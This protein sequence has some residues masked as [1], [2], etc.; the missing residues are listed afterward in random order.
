MS[1]DKQLAYNFLGNI[2]FERIGGTAEENKAVRLLCDMARSFEAIPIVERFG[3]KT[4]TK[5]SAGLEILTPYQTKYS[6]TPCALSGSFPKSGKI[7]SLAH[8]G[9]TSLEALDNVKGKA[10]YGYRCVRYPEHFRLLKNSGVAC[11]VDIAAFGKKLRYGRLGD[12]LLTKIG[13]TPMIRIPFEAGMEMIQKGATKGRITLKQGEKNAWSKNVIVVVNG[14]GVAKEEIVICAHHDS[15]PDSPGANDNGGGSAIMVSLLKHFKHNPVRRTLR[16]IWFG[17]EEQGLLGSQSYV[18]T[19]A[20]EMGNVA[21]VV[22]IDGAGRLIDSS[23]AVV[24]GQDNLRHFV[25]GIGKERGIYFPVSEGVFGSDNIPFSWHE[26]PSINIT[27]GD[28]DNGFVHSANDD[29]RWCG[30]DGLA[31]NGEIALEIIERLGNAKQF[32]FQ[33]GFN[34]KVRKSLNAFY[35]ELLLSDEEMPKWCTVPWAT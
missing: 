35:K 26:I 24:A 22:N 4:F 29:Y 2:A 16:F 17:S 25:D 8:V 30:A 14:T 5:G 3:I 34:E 19:H 7:L 15:V 9:A 13:P 31:P 1:F 20:K 11:V 10:I 6:A 23:H 33:H 28:D 21:M 18:K 27:R 12:R 32:P